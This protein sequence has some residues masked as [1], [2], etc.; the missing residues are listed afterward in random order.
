MLFR[1][2]QFL[3]E[4]AKTGVFEAWSYAQ[5]DIYD[6]WTWM[7][8]PK[9]LRP[10]VP[11]ALREAAELVYEHGGHLGEVQND[12]LQRLNAKWD[13]RIVD[14]VR[15]IVRSEEAPRKRL[16][17]LVDFVREAGLRIPE[18]VQPLPPIELADIRVVC[19]MAVVP[20]VLEIGRAHV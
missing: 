15:L 10:E 4:A 13:K 11:L 17:R 20:E 8:D 7:T 19:W 6:A 9:N 16:D 3:P 12:L 14:E 5:R 2:E 1:S 18:K